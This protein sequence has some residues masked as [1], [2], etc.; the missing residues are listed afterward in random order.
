MPSP[1]THSICKRFC[2]LALCMFSISHIALAEDKASKEKSKDELT[3][4]H[5][6]GTYTI[7]RGEVEGKKLKGQ[8]LKTKK[9]VFK[10]QTIKTLDMSDGELFVAEFQLQPHEKGAY[11]VMKSIKPPMPGVAAVGLIKMKEDKVTL[12]YAFPNAEAP[13]EYVTTKGQHM[14]VMKK[15][16][17]EPKTL[18]PGVAVP[19]N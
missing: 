18:K 7:T 5:L 6:E 8:E 15:Q 11:I 14:F 10:D 3:A 12:I 17:D 9:V 13:E 2:L 1:T 16:A 4:K 19:G